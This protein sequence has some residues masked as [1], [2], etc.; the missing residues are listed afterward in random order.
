MPKIFISIVFLC[1]V[2]ASQS[3]TTSI[4]ARADMMQTIQQKN[5]IPPNLSANIITDMI[6]VS[7]NQISFKN[8]L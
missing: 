5:A 1:S 3:R 2:V 7:T 6:Q 8:H 4:T